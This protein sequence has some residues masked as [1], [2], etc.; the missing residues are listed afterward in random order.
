MRIRDL[1]IYIL[2]N[3]YD[4]YIKL[5]HTY[6]DHIHKLYYYHIL[7]SYDKSL[8]L[9]ELTDIHKLL[10]EYYNDKI[11]NFCE[12]NNDLDHDILK[13]EIHHIISY[14][15]KMRLV[16]ELKS[17]HE[18]FYDSFYNPLGMIKT[19]IKKLSMN[20]GYPNIKIA[21]E[22]MVNESYIYDTKTK[23][24]IENYNYLYKPIKCIEKDTK[25]DHLDNFDLFTDNVLI[26]ESTSETNIFVPY[27]DFYI[28]NEFNYIILKGIFIPDEISLFM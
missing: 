3:D 27:F 19:N 22:L 11:I 28:K 7:S 10:N 12:T 20:I 13:S 24:L 23:L 15:N 9:N 2:K 18:I 25:V 17:S 4:K 5:L 21:I 14:I 16:P 26:K 6:R 8:Y 1:K